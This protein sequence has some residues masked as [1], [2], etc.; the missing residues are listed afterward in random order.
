LKSDDDNNN[1]NNNT[2][3]TREI[4]VFFFFPSLAAEKS[5]CVKYA[6]SPAFGPRNAQMPLFEFFNLLAPEFGI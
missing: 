2:V 1:N 3:F 5:G 6:D 4:C